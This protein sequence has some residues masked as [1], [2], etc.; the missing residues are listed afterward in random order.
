[1]HKS[2]AKHL[3]AAIAAL[4]CS[5]AF[6]Q[7]TGNSQ[8]QPTNAVAPSTMPSQ[9]GVVYPG[10][11]MT[12][13]QPL[14]G[15]LP[16][17]RQMPQPGQLASP[18]TP[19]TAIG[20]VPPLPAVGAV[21][22]KMP[23]LPTP[24][25]QY[26]NDNMPAELPDTV[27][28]YKRRFEEAQRAV[29][30]FP[31]TAPTPISRSTTITQAPGELATTVRLASGIPSNIVFTDS[32][33]ATWPIEFA[34]PGDL[35]VVDVLVPVEGSATLQLRPKQAHMYG[36]VSV[37]LKGNPV[38]ITLILASAQVEVD[39]RLDIR[40]ARRG[41]NAQAPI[42]D[43]PGFTNVDNVMLS[44]LDG[45]PPSDAQSLKSAIADLRA[46]IYKGKLYVRTT[47]PVVS[48]AY[49]DTAASIDGTRVYV[50][51]SVPFVTVSVD[52]MLRTVRIGE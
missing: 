28:E 46:W 30:Q 20:Q 14:A 52:G 36:A 44:V 38:P 22:P 13:G 39:T 25:Q 16:G 42:I 21:A 29:S 49:S 12:E 45:V 5:G 33:G 35:S 19:G 8:P 23:A 1:M 9:Q 51:P 37:N 11:Q 27:R 43:R 48:P 4:A 34:T 10:R 31:V 15:N 18:G 2:P 26:L 17:N 7:Q 24:A 50:M 3:A 40:V 41:P 6:A 32:T 47:M